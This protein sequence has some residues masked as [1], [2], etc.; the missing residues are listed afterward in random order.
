MRASIGAP[1]G[2]KVA[3]RHVETFLEMIVV[4]RGAAANTEQAYRRDL[5]DFAAFAAGRGQAPEKAD[6]DLVRRY[7][8][9]LN[10]SGL[11]ARTAARRLS[12]LRQ[13][14]RFLFAEG[15]RRDD[16]CATID[17]PKIGRKLP[18]VLNE[19]QVFALL[20]AA[21]EAPGVD[22]LR[23]VA[24]M[25]LLYATGLRVSELVGLT[26]S[27]LS[28]DRQVVTVRGKGGKERM[29]PL[30]APAR[31]AVEAYLPFRMNFVP[32]ASSSPWLFPSRGSSGHLTRDGFMRMIKQ[33]AV[34]AGLDPALVSP[35]V[36][37]HAFASHLLAHD[38]DLRSVQQMLGHADI[39]T[40]Q[41]YTHVLEER[42]T[43]LVRGR[44]PLARGRDA[45]SPT[46]NAPRTTDG[47]DIG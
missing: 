9:R 39:S 3:S 45:V 44:H 11:S 18:R 4:E 20:R 19:D 21:R 24:L 42:L 12:A 13:F 34:E 32:Q 22:G 38:A 23:L 26:V 46:R 6:T 10:D 33:L 40:T 5:N 14:F 41:I 1:A 31:D 28:R 30:G 29:I 36:L 2:P 27:T 8:E 17:S 35:H 47:H 25:E 43:S 15:I 37:R 7:L 16:P